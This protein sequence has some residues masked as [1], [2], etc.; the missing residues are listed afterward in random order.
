MSILLS[1]AASVSQAVT[2][3]SVLDVSALL[4]RLIA[5][6][7]IL[8]RWRWAGVGMV[9]FVFQFYMPAASIFWLDALAPVAGEKALD[10]WQ[11]V[12]EITRVIA[13]VALLIS[14]RQIKRQS[15]LNPVANSKVVPRRR[16]RAR[17]RPA[18]T[19]TARD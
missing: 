14:L 10:R 18:K 19:T 11:L 6:A 1:S 16:T 13:V 5:G 9:V 2:W 8:M 7:L 15:D 12:T 4:L 3:S 17:K